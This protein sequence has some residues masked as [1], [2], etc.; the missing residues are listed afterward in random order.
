[1]LHVHVLHVYVLHVYDSNSSFTAVQAALRGDESAPP[2]SSRIDSMSLVNERAPPP[3][4]STPRPPVPQHSTSA[5]STNGRRGSVNRNPRSGRGQE[6][7]PPPH[8]PQQLPPIPPLPS[9][10]GSS[11]GQPKPKEP[12]PPISN[13]STSPPQH[14]NPPLPNRGPNRPSAKVPPPTRAPPPKRTSSTTSRG[15]PGVPEKPQPPSRQRGEAENLSSSKTTSGSSAGPYIPPRQPSTRGTRPPT[16]SKPPVPGGNRPKPTPPSRP[17]RKPT[18]LVS[19]P[20]SGGHTQKQNGPVDIPTG[21]NMSAKEMAECIEREVPAILGQIS[22]R[23]TSVPQHLE[24]LATLLENFADN[25]RGSG[26][27]FRITMSSLRSQIG[28]LQDN[29]ISV[30]QTNS[31]SIIEALNLVQQHIKSMS[32][33]LIN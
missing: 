13:T 15:A 5:P 31:E 20:A 16:P 30:W 2:P 25:A 9:R 8:R 10:T 18:G 23:S 28:I 6:P 4:P 22:E 32:K 3:I 21:E 33:N 14:P 7:L 27:Q 1:M 24:S 19:P 17:G 26:V 11:V 29:A 12:S